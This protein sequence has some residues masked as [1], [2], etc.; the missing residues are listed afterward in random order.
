M[1]QIM[2]FCALTTLALSSVKVPADA[3]VAVMPEAGV[4]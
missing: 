2:M 3:G 1:V 4:T